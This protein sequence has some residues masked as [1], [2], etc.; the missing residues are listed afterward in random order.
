MQDNN[1][2]Q[3]ARNFIS[4]LPYKKGEYSGRNWGHNFHSLCSYHGKLK[5]AIAFHLV[6]IFTK[7]GDVVLDPLCGVGTIP[8][9]ACNNGR[10]GIGNDL[11]EMAYIVSKAKLEKPSIEEV[12]KS[13]NKLEKYI[14]NNKNS[15]HIKKECK[16][17]GEFGFNGKLSL[18]FH[19]ETFKEIV[20]ARDYFIKKIKNISPADAMV[21]S[22]FL[23]V[24]HGNRPY[25]LSRISHPLTPYAPKGKFTYKNVIEHIRN[26][27]EI[28]YKTDNFDNY[29]KGKAFFGDFS[30]IKD[31]GIK[32]D[33]I[34]TSPPFANSIKF[35][36]QNWMR[37]WLCGWEKD[38]FKKADD[39]FI[40]KKQI[41][42]FDIYIPFFQMC[43]SVLKPKG[44]LI[45][46]LG[47]SKDIDMA[48][49][50]SKRASKYF[51]EIYRGNEN[52]LSL[53]KHGIKDKGGTIEHQFLFLQR[54]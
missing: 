54:K 52:V 28:V 24:L 35:Y 10:I 4:S 48:E 50:L 27:I 39:E 20:T 38:D 41:K 53:E 23:H 47:K 8:F 42:D 6:N 5:P 40:D 18:Y 36:I 34:I 46:H 43:H 11:S 31:Y 19:S 15:S 29:K 2:K 14:E 49:E 7:K 51:V 44:K 33:A 26:K 37:L 12:N 32:A 13:I 16:K 21:Y 45:L 30:K 22:S 1:Y 17:H 25:A 3:L 9:E